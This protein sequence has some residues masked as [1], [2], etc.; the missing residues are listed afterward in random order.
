MLPILKTGNKYKSISLTESLYTNW[1]DKIKIDSVYESVSYM[2][3]GSEFESLK[4]ND[5]LVLLVGKELL[6]VDKNQFIKLKSK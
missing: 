1:A 5:G 6:V 4:W 3:L 2:S